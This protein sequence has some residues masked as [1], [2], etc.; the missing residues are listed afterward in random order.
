MRARVDV[1]V[2]TYNTAELTVSALRRLLDSDQGCDLRV[3]VHDNA[4]SDGTPEALAAGVPEAEVVAGDENLGFARAVNRILARSEAPWFLALNSDA[5][6]EPGAVRTLVGAAEAHPRAAVVA[7]LLLRPDGTQE[8]STHPFPTVPVALLDALGGRSWLP[9][10]RLEALALEGAWGQD[11]PRA[12]DWAVG[13]ALLFRRE[14]LEELGGLDERFFMYVEDLDW[15][16]RAREA[17]WEVR[18]EPAAVVRHVGNA[19][20]EA[21]FG[22]GRLALE[23]ANLYRFLSGTRK[24]AAVAAYRALSVVGAARQAL[25]A[26]LREGPGGGGPGKALALAHLGLAPLPVLGSPPAELD[27]PLGS[28]EV[29]VCVATHGRA[30]LLPRLVAALEAQTLDPDRFE[31]VIVDDG[32]PDATGDVLDDLAAR[33][34]LRLRVLRLPTRGGPAAA[35]NLAWRSTGARVVAFTDDDCVPVPGWLEAGLAALGGAKMVVGRTAPP[36]EQLDLVGRVVAVESV[37]F[38]ETCNVFYRRTDLG[39]VGG[40]EE[41]FRRPSGEDT[42]LGLSVVGLGVEPVFCPG[43]LVHHDVRKGRLGETLRE[44][45][46]W[47]DL[48]LVLRRHPSAR[49]ELTHRW[50]FWKPTH[51]PA[52]LAA[53]GLLLGLRWRPVLL[54]LTPWIHHRLRVTATRPGAL[55]GALAVDLAELAV[56]ARGSVRHRTVLL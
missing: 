12:V 27:P 5:W 45:T 48:P 14:A 43:A 4:S 35:R 1:G 18:F 44:T 34:P 56:M 47:V 11:R 8:H 22:S 36:P 41:G 42:H 39:A 32:S 19:S 52:L 49:R 24:P 54:L 10:R 26:R 55:P 31:V 6:P 13:A 53:A 21:R 9:R 38:F 29:A 15:C 7:P 20:G 28:V 40:F 51:P 3:L 25:G 30:G 23:T 2:V 33:S 17:G 50:V 16:W 37:R 46:R